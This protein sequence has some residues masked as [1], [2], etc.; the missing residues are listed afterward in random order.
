MAISTHVF[1]N[2]VIFF[3]VVAFLQLIKQNGGLQANIT[4]DAAL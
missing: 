4:M 2:S 1:C 3:K